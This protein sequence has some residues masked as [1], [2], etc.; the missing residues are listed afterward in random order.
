MTKR[1]STKKNDTII[2][3]NGLFGNPTF[4][5]ALREIAN[6]KLHAVTAFKINKLV[7]AIRVKITDYEE[8]RTKL[9]KELGEETED[10]K[11]FSFPDKKNRDKFE[12]EMDELDS[13]DIKFDI[14]KI[15]FPNSIELTPIQIGAIE[16]LFIFDEQS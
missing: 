5:G 16:D 4:H 1:K 2:L 14:E 8:I 6:S 10:K 9:C 11:G 12:K 7:K 3:K 15:K 13:L